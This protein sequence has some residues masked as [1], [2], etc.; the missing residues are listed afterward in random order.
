MRSSDR[1]IRSILAVSALSLATLATP[2]ASAAG[3]DPSSATAAQKKEAMD[4]FTAGKQAFEE[5]NYEKAAM[6][7]RASLDVVNSPNARLELARALR[8]GGKLD[9]AWAEYERVV[10]DATKLAAKEPRYTKTADAATTERTDVESKLA[11]V[12]V[13]VAHARASSRRALG[14]L[15][16][17]SDARSSMAAFS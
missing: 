4:H 13:T 1:T 2:L 5:K 16:T 7:L 15:T 8:D 11:F 3:A 12:I 6:E 9:Q 14:L 17:S 10:Q